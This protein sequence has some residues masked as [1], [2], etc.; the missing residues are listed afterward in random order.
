MADWLEPIC[1]GLA[2]AWVLAPVLL[3]VCVVRVVSCAAE[4]LVVCVVSCAAVPAERNAMEDDCDGELVVA[5]VLC[6]ILFCC[7]ASPD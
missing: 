4:L 2:L 5:D 6:V 3:V 7:R 1:G